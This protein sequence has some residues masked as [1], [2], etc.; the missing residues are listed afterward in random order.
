MLG[1]VGAELSE[2]VD[3]EEI[4]VGPAVFDVGVSVETDPVSVGPSVETE[5]V[6][7]ED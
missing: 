7:T 2:D 5:W 4:S 1:P 3:N 6:V